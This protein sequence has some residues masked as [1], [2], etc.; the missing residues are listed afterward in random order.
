MA[1][2][3]VRGDFGAQENKVCHC[4]HLMGGLLFM[5]RIPLF[6]LYNHVLFQTRALCK[7]SA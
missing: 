5:D 3:T 1:A 6:S 2:V 4:F 7:N